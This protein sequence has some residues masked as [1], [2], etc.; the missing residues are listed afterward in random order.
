MAP[1]RLCLAAIVG[2]HGVRG[3]VRLKTFTEVPE[4]VAG[5]GPLS[6]E[7]GARWFRLTL[8]GR[9]KDLLLAAIEGVEDRDAAEALRGT[10]LYLERGRLPEPEDPG[11]F[12]VAD[13]VG[14][15]VETAAGERLGR[16]SQVV[17][18]G[19]GPIL[20][21]TPEAGPVFD[22]PFVEAVV[23]TVD[24]AGGRLVVEPPPGEPPQDPAEGPGRE[25]PGEP[26]Q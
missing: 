6:D 16:V 2:A 7:A 21:V 22:L 15:A 26:E 8:K 23:P 10:R 19:A 9:V 11:E 13:L 17:D 25:P 14:L 3:L 20:E 1:K 12:Y 24:I 5:Y 18:H 4:A